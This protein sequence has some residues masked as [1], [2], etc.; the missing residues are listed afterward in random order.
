MNR[1]GEEPRG[2]LDQVSRLNDAIQ[3][4]DGHKLFFRECPIGIGKFS[5]MAQQGTE[6][7]AD[8]RPSIIIADVA[9]LRCQPFNCCFS[10]FWRQI[11]KGFYQAAPAIRRDANVGEQ[12][13]A[14]LLSTLRY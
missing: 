6:R 1:V 12:A 8:L 14:D 7:S 9:C 2:S 13:T 5:V 4:L 3:H 11:R 10:L